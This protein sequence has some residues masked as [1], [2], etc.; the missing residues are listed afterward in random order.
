[1]TDMELTLL[2]AADNSMTF[3]G[4]ADGLDALGAC[5]LEPNESS[6]RLTPKATPPLYVGVARVIDVRS[7]GQPGLEI[8][9]NGE[10]V[11][12]I[13]DPAS[14]AS[15]AENLTRL[16]AAPA[17]VGNHLHIEYYPDHPYIRATSAPVIV[18]MM[19]RDTP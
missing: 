10:G 18:E 8:V 14:R 16:T 2:F 13:G 12:I 7:D 11:D 5:L 1:M 17:M 3:I 15:L 6:L 19:P 4:N 9:R